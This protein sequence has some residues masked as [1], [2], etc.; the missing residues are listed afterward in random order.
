MTG[1]TTLP[2]LLAGLVLLAGCRD[3]ATPSSPEPLAASDLRAF[4]TPELASS[5]SSDGTFKLP[6]PPDGLRV[7]PRRAQELALAF[8]RTFGP[9]FLGTF[10]RE[11]GQSISLETLQVGS[12]AYYAET[13]FGSLPE[14]VH[15]GLRNV[16]GPYYMVYLVSPDG[17]PVLVVGVSGSTE[18]WIK[19]GRLRFPLQYGADFYTEGVRLG[20]GFAKPLSPEQAVRRVGEGTGVPVSALPQLFRPDH[21]YHPVF[22]RWKVTLDRP[23]AVRGRNSESTQQVREL[24]VGLRGEFSVPSAVQPKEHTRVDFMTKRTLRVP[25]HPDHPVAFEPVALSNP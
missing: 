14:D 12:P 7:S 20:E 22:A 10:E 24:Y 4:V 9:Y 13:P 2:I 17:A 25:V 16:Y 3:E 15:P 11:H 5:L 19:N 18:A 23:I 8:A 6:A 1:K 21:G